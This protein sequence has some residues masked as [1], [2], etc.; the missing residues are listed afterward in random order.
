MFLYTIYEII[1][2]NFKGNRAKRHACASSNICRMAYAITVI[3]SLDR[4]LGRQ[5]YGHKIMDNKDDA[6]RLT[7][8]ALKA[9]QK[10]LK[11]TRESKSVKQSR[12]N[13][14]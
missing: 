9:T 3:S 11:K 4:K 7:R 10:C 13:F 6:F 8:D 5:K 12:S 2:V 1:K 14:R